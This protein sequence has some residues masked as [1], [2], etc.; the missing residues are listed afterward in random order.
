LRKRYEIVHVVVTD[1][2]FLTER[3]VNLGNVLV[4]SY[5]QM[6]HMF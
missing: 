2:V 5:S 4:L 6:E 1:D 3:L